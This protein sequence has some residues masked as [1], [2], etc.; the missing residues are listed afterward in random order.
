MRFLKR[1]RRPKPGVVPEVVPE[2]R[3][4]SV[5]ALLLDEVDAAHGGGGASAGFR[6]V[7]AA[8]DQVVCLGGQVLREF[9]LHIALYARAQKD[10]AQF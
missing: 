9:G 4:A 1:R 2:G 8:S 10:G 5:A 7:D 3:A 6:R